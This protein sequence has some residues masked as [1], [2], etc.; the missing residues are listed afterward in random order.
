MGERMKWHKSEDFIWPE[1]KFNGKKKK[2]EQSHLSV[3]YHLL[4]YFKTIS[5]LKNSVTVQLQYHGKR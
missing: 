3:F 4:I 2:Q 1:L 5:L